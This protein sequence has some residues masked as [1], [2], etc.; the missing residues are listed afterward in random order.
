MIKSNLSL[1]FLLIIAG[2]SM[3]SQDSVLLKRSAY[4][5]TVAVSKNTF[6][7]ESLQEKA[8][9]LPGNTVQLYPGETVFIEIE[10]SD[11]VIKSL[12]AVKEI[13][14][15]SKTVTINFAQAVNKNIHEQMML[16]VKNPFKFNL[17]YE[18]SIFLYNQKKW[19]STSIIP[20][21]SGL[22]GIETWP[23]IIISI[24]LDNWKLEK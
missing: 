13:S 19:V 21:E 17:V 14:D 23:D 11:G 4:K 3:Y 20:V 8:Y 16:T 18:A 15:A 24:A 5:L 7:E 9:V 6:Y 2:T 22:L 1:L 12:K 10:Q